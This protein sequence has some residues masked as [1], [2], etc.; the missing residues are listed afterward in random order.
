MKRRLKILNENI[1]IL[2]LINASSKIYYIF[3]E[4]FIRYLKPRF[5]RYNNITFNSLQIL[6][7][8]NSKWWTA[9]VGGLMT[10]IPTK[11]FL[12]RNFSLDR[13]N[14]IQG[15]LWIPNHVE[16][17]KTSLLFLKNVGQFT[18][19]KDIYGELWSPISERDIA[20]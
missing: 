11:Y 4:S 15:D 8:L 2:N 19:N 7:I 20:L 1:E 16:G 3:L 17:H 13:I 12:F 5:A 9:K 10:T 6:I 14:I 18:G